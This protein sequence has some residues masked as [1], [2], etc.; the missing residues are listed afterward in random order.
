[1]I[2]RSLCHRFAER[3]L[4]GVA[5]DL[6]GGR[7]DRPTVHSLIGG[8]EPTTQG[9]TT[10]DEQTRFVVSQIDRHLAEGL[11]PEDIAVFAPKR[12][13]LIRSRPR[14]RLQDATTIS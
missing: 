6:D 4:H 14:C 11:Q 8:P 2:R 7:D 1:L 5:A 9:F 12:T 3:I 10:S 13:C